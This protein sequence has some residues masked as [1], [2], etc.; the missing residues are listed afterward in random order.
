[1][2][3][4]PIAAFAAVSHAASPRWNQTLSPNFEIY[5]ESSFL[6]SGTTLKLGGMHGRLRRDLSMFAPWMAKERVKVYLYK[7][8]KSYVEGEFQPPAWSNGVAFY[9]RKLIATYEVKPQAKIFSVLA[10]EMAHLFFESYW[11]EEKKLPPVWLN[12]GLAML[13]EAEDA[14]NPEKSE[15]YL[16]MEILE[17]GNYLPFHRFMKI[18]PTRDL[19]NSDRDTVT[20]WYVQAYSMVYFLYRKHSRLQ[21]LNFCKLLRDG[22]PLKKVLWQVY[23]FQS[24][25]KFEKAW[26]DWLKLPK[27]RLRAVR[28]SSA[29][30]ETPKD[31]RSKRWKLKRTGFRNFHYNSFVPDEKK[32][33]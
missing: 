2:A 8:K 3:L 13:E 1:M 21:F 10:H 6:P 29:R 14:K 17:G 20:L 11:G 23:R 27:T 22:K 18:Q 26:R 24:L 5:H 12:E 19:A 4:L 9:D 25:A 33:R 15:W 32:R 7:S 28:R 16:S 31:E 30:V